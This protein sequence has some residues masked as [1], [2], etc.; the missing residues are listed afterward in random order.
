MEKQKFDA[1]Q[2][3]GRLD[4]K[5]RKNQINLSVMELITKLTLSTHN[6][7]S[8]DNTRESEWN[9]EVIPGRRIKI[10]KIF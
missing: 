7:S 1:K 8:F 10:E 4:I 9:T 5:S 2:L 6:S 3:L